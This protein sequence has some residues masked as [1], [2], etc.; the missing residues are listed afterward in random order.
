MAEPGFEWGPGVGELQWILEPWAPP[1]PLAP[2]PNVL[3]LVGA[4]GKEEAP[5]GP[6]GHPESSGSLLL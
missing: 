1:L 2:T 4:G 5:Q 6:V 3:V